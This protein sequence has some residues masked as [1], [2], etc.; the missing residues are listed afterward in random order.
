M[1]RFQPGA[2]VNVRN[3]DWVVMPS[4]DEDLVLIKPLGGSDEEVTGIYLPLEFEGDEIKSAEFP[5][6]TIENIGA[7]ERAKILYNA[8]RL[9][10]RNGAGPFRSL[11]KL[12]FRPRSYQMVPL[13]MALKQETTR[14]LIADDVGVGKTIE[15]LLIVKELLERKEIKRF[16]IVCLPHLCEQWQFEIKDKFDIDAVIIRSNTQAKLDREIQGDESVYSLYP[17]QIISIDYIKS[18]VRR[19]VFVNECPE[20][21]IVDEVHTCTKPDGSGKKTQH[22]RYN[23]VNDIS[24]KANQH[25][26]LLTATPHSGKAEQFQSLLGLLNPSFETIDLT[27]AIPSDR[28]KLSGHF[29]QRKRVDV[30]HWMNEDTPFPKRD[31]GEFPYQLSIPYAMFYDEI[32]SFARGLT[33]N[34]EGKKGHQRLRYW[35]A[36]ALMRGVMS[37]PAAGIKMLKNRIN[38]TASDEELTEMEHYENP[39]LDND[40]GNESDVTPLQVVEKNQ[41]KS[42]EVKKL[43]QLAIQLESIGNLK[44]DTKIKKVLDIILEWVNKGFNPVIFCR[45]IAT[46]QYVGE[47]LKPALQ[48]KYKNLDLQVITSEDPDEVR[49]ERIDAMGKSKQRVLIATDCLSEGINLQ[50]Y[51]NAVLH[52]DLPWNPN[53]LEQREGRV[54]RFGQKSESVKAYLLF[55]EDNPIDGVVLKVIL[56][57][58]REIKKSLGISMPFPD[59]SK[60]ILDAVLYAVLLNPKKAQKTTQTTLDFGYDQEIKDK[61]LVATKAIE[62]AA[63]REIKTRSIFAQNAIKAQEIEEDLKDVDEAIGNPEAVEDFIVQSMSVLGVQLVED[64]KGYSLYTTNLPYGLKDTLPAEEIVKISFLSP[65]P[66]GYMYIGRNQLFVEQL[67]QY[68]LANSFSEELNTHSLSRTSVVSTNA[69]RTK[70]TILMFRVRNVIEDVGK[71]K[72]LIAEEML[73][74][75]YEGTAQDKKFIDLEKAKS[76][77]NMVVPSGSLAEVER[78]FLLSNEL[79]NIQEIKTEFDR[80]ALNRAEKLVEAHERFRKVLGGQ[81]YKVVHPVLP[82]DV[83]GIYILLPQND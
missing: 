20:M 23:L 81:K 43:R 33:E 58:V 59:D 39:I 13:I 52:Y 32:L 26:V 60:S 37:S 62:E 70:T 63:Q 2:L 71:T 42:T 82:M 36:L 19:Q 25:L 57:K 4:N 31:A 72:Q 67:C 16:A 41:W 65:T 69:V 76:L 55:G 74:M 28:K 66:E 45:Y 34:K 47:L 44:D 73:V 75:G 78:N 8:A 68:L 61:E 1:E 17:F 6:P 7:F 14:L 24:K 29:I 22:Q 48:K 50:E 3:R 5:I 64:K 11:A 30:E 15:S 83:M 79:D 56:K 51:F 49:K 12:S 46:A 54:D 80:V 21:V 9:S 18:D 38:N 77:L 10:F 35:T 53:R 27:Q 40:Y